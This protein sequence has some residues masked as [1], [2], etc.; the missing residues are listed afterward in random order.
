MI[1]FAGRA[2]GF[3]SIL[4]IFVENGLNVLP[5]SPPARRIIRLPFS[6]R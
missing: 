1:D 6:R 5:L 4:R 2:D 3:V